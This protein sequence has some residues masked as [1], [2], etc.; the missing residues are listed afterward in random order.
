MTRIALFKSGGADILNTNSQGRVATDMQNAGYNVVS[1][2]SGPMALMVDSAN[3]DSPF[4][5]IKVRQAMEYAI[6][7]E[8]I[9]KTFGAGWWQAAYQFSSSNSKGYD[10]SIAGRK[11]DVAKAK[12]LM[13]DAG[14]PNGFKTTMTAGPLF[15]NRDVVITIQSYLSKIG[16]QV[17]LQF[18]DSAK[19]AEINTNPWKNGILYT[20]VNEW[21]NQ[22][23]GFN[24]YYGT[25][26][27]IYKSVAKPEGWAALLEASKATPE[28]D[29][30]M[31][32]KMEN[33]IYD[34]SMLIPIYNGSNIWAQYS[35]VQDSGVGTHGLPAWFDPDNVWFN[36]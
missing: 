23:V 6:D 5:N 20:S 33:M 4:S 7:K 12:Q 21:G 27:A 34:N 30:T 17:D 8:A 10:P 1:L 15:L 32:K 9:A 25:P 2:L 11:Y 28:P 36:K 3:A 13:S 29:P 24:Y 18:P 19:W 35:Y 31:L 16:M 14:Y 26:A 22:N